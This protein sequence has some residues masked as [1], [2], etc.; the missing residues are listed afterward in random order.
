MVIMAMRTIAR[1]IRRLCGEFVGKIRS[2]LSIMIS[3]RLKSHMIFAIM[4]YPSRIIHH[5]G[6]IRSGLLSSLCFFAK[7][8]KDL[9]TG[10]RHGGCPGKSPKDLLTF[11]SQIV[12]NI[13]KPIWGVPPVIHFSYFYILGCSMK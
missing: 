10:F 1:P 13:E 6:K 3:S 5:V 12:L 8:T 9:L 4:N 7:N 11:W 2:E